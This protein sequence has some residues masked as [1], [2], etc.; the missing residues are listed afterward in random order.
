MTSPSPSTIEVKPKNFKWM[1]P[2]LKQGMKTARE[3]QRQHRRTGKDSDGETW[4]QQ[5]RQVSKELRRARKVYALKGLRDKAAY[6]KSMWQG[7]KAHLGWE[8]TGAPTRLVK[9]PGYREN[10]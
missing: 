9:Q 6:S 7:A 10:L 3:L 2:S 8:N 5:R 4:K 1:T